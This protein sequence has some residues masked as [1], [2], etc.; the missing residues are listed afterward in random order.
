MVDRNNGQISIVKQCKLLGISRSTLYYVPK[1]VDRTEEYQIKWLIDQIYTEHP[2]FGY[3]RMTT[4]LRRD[5]SIK[6]NK[7]RT[8]RYMRDMAIHGLC[9]GPNLS[10]REHAKYLY[11]YLLRR[12][13]INQSNQVWSIDITYLRMPKGHMYLCAIIDWH[14][15]FIVGYEL[16]TTMD[17]AFVLK[18]V[19]KAIEAHGKPDIINSDQG[20]QFSC[21]AYVDLLKSND[22]KISMDGRGKALDNIRIERFWRN[23]KWEKTYLEEYSTPKQLRRI[24]NEYMEHYNYSRPH[25]SL[26]DQ[27]PAEVYNGT[28]AMKLVA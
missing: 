16:S 2:E 14:S 11:P 20:S 21:A 7:K 8:R 9:P 17:K 12:M 26:E 23:L 4:I 3:R 13:T 24:V 22:I 6:I 10:K 19:E 1:P 15:R 18:T 28:P 5:Y 27:T 25:Q